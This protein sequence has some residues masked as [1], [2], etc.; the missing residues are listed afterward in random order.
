MLVIKNDVSKTFPPEK[1]LES[2]HLLVTKKSYDGYRNRKLITCLHPLELKPDVR[3]LTEES[4]PT[5]NIYPWHKLMN[6]LET[7]QD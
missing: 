5:K 3:N 6:H 2:R 7:V 4:L 1:A